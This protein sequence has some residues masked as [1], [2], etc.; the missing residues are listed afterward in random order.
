[1]RE[2]VGRLLEMGQW[3]LCAAY[4]A[5]CQYCVTT[6]FFLHKETGY[7]AQNLGSSKS[8][9]WYRLSAMGHP[10]APSP[11]STEQRPQEYQPEVEAQRSE[12]RKAVRTEVLDDHKDTMFSKYSWRS[13][14]C[15]LL[16]LITSLL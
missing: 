13:Q 14:A 5:I 10:L 3:E 11:H 4:G 15:F 1:M 6:E 12:S 2:G 16:S 9:A 8:T 7:L